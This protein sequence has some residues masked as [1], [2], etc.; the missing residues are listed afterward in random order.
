MARNLHERLVSEGHGGSC[1]PVR[2]LVRDPKRA[3][4]GSSEA[5]I[6]LHLAA[7]DALQFDWSE[8][9]VVPGGVDQRVKVAHFRPCHGRKPLVVTHRG[10]AWKMVPDAFLRTLSVHGGVPRRVI[11]DN[12]GTMVPHVS[13]SKDRTFQHWFP[14]SMDHHAMEPVACTPAAG[15]EKGQIENRVRFVEGGRPFVPMPVFD[16]LDAPND[17][18]CLRCEALADR[19]HPERSDCTIAEV[20]EDGRGALRPRG[21]PSTA[22]W[23]RRFVS[24]SWSNMPAIA[25]ACHPGSRGDMCRCARMRAGSWW[26]W[27]RRSLPNTSA[28]SRERRSFRALAHH[29]PLLDRKPGALRDGAPFA[30][31][32]LPDAMHRIGEHCMAGKGGDREFV[33]LLLPARDHGIEVVETACEP[34]V[35]QDTLRLPAIIDPIHRLEEPVMAPSMDVHPQPTLRPEADCRR[36]EAP[37]AGEAAA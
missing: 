11:I 18:L 34:A 28:A 36:H 35:E 20:F 5:F 22:M 10:E 17:R 33:D 2:R 9:R 19:P 12:P 37:V 7:G 3:G 1:S 13:D 32:R 21:G 29:V 31:W 15:R 16:D 23:R 27:A 6:P 4:A 26:C 24:A 30:D 14:A 25:T 8:E